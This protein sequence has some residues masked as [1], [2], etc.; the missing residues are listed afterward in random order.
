MQDDYHETAFA[1]HSVLNKADEF[2]KAA[3]S[4]H[5]PYTHRAIEI[6]IDQ[7]SIATSKKAARLGGLMSE[8]ET[9]VRGTSDDAL[10]RH[11]QL[12]A[13]FN[14]ECCQRDLAELADEL[15][16]EKPDAMR[17]EFLYWSIIDHFCRVERVAPAAVYDQECHFSQEKYL[18]LATRL[19]ALST[20]HKARLTLPKDDGGEHT[21][22]FSF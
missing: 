17:N 1:R 4:A 15:K 3:V 9:R 22:E 7:D 10:D 14:L 2:S 5:L 8:L 6:Y 13:L 11:D 16:R 18:Q 21:E 20:G 19:L 12:L